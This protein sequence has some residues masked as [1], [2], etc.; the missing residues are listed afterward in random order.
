MEFKILENGNLIESPRELKNIGEYDVIVC[1][2]G[3]AGFGAAIAASRHGAKVL[4]IERE[5]ALGGLATV[6]LVPIPL[7]IPVGIS[8]EMVNRL[9]AL[10]GYTRRNSNPELH[11]L[12]LDRMVK[13]ARI[14]LLLDT[15][16]VDAVVV[17]NQIRGVVLESK[18]GRQVVWG[19]RFIDCTGDAD[20]AYFAGCEIM[21]GRES[22]GKHQACSIDFRLG[23]VDYN[24][25]VESDLKADDP[26]WVKLIETA[27]KDGRMPIMYENHLNWSVFVPGRPKNCGKDE[28]CLCISHSRNCD[29]LSNV[30]L[31][32]MYLEGRE[33]AA[34]F[35]RFIKENVPGFENSYLI[36]TANLLGVRESRRVLGEYVLK[37]LDFARKAK[38]DDAITCT[39]HHFDLHNPDGVGNIK[40]AKEIIDG[41]V[42]YVSS[43]GNPGSLEPP[44]G[45]ENMTDGWGRT[46]ADRVFLKDSADIPYRSLVPV[47]I[48]NLLVAGRCLSSEFMAQAASR[49]ILCCV[50]MG[51]AA[52]TAAAQSLKEN[53]VPRKI[54]IKKLQHQL[55]NDRNE[56]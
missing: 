33:Q 35:S 51:Q 7:D 48:D 31:T 17:D 42:C 53:T 11:K 41:K 29:P 10:D 18:S 39:H 3:M 16:I 25:Y 30:D 52:G 40:W 4:L 54:D 19:K 5:T 9:E 12:V 28:I 55:K 56:I 46:G 34:F 45:Y 47:K 24:K 49:L 26:R 1:G 32:R 22:D 43:T 21:S 38:F 8:L 20:V 37:T 15:A 50:N 2:G 6:G 44:C 36:D 14:E 23:G 13:E 27:H